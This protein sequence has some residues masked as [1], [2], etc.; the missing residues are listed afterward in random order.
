MITK[1]NNDYVKVLRNP[2]NTSECKKND[3]NDIHDIYDYID[4]DFKQM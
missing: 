3:N 2:S 4:N 1:F